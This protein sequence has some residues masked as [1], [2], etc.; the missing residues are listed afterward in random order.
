MDTDNPEQSAEQNQNQVAVAVA[1]AVPPNGVPQPQ[2]FKL[3]TD[4]LDKVFD[5]LSMRD[6]LSFGRTCKGLK[7]VAGEYLKENFSQRRPQCNEEGYLYDANERCTVTDFCQYIQEIELQGPVTESLWNLVSKCTSLNHIELN[8]VDLTETSIKVIE[9]V[10]ETVEKISLDCEVEGNVYDN[11]LK[12]CVSLKYLRFTDYTG[13]L[14]K[15]PALERLNLWYDGPFE[16]NELN[17]FFELNPQVRNLSI[18]VYILENRDYLTNSNINLDNLSVYGVCG[19][20]FGHV[21][22]I[23]SELYQRGFYKNLHIQIWSS[24]SK[25]ELATLQG[26]TTL[27]V[28]GNVELP[29]MP[30]LKELGFF[31]DLTNLRNEGLNVAEI[32]KLCSHLERLFIIESCVD[33]F[34]PFICHSQHLVEIEIAR[35]KDVVVDVTALNNE[36]RKLK[37]A[38]KVKL[39]VAEDAYLATKW[40]TKDINLSLI[41]LKRRDSYAT[42]LAHDLRP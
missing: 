1:G 17:T 27:H 32:P 42:K 26:L 10:L 35:L 5:C 40:A 30:S 9:G 23:L 15:Y 29:S 21:L 3:N 14:Q 39:Y 11:F 24:P 6:I 7:W 41:E 13:L 36:R 20:D 8:C 22:D 25:N 4:C 16:N 38:R 19:E 34:M 31:A 2:I 33:D 37:G 12:R 18:M 28:D